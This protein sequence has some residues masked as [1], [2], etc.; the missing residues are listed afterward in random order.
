M[1]IIE[2]FQ[3]FSGEFLWFFCLKNP[4]EEALL[5][6]F[7]GAWLYV[8]NHEIWYIRKNVQESPRET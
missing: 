2:I 8:E 7:Q 5:M 6:Q 4:T 1:K 3:L